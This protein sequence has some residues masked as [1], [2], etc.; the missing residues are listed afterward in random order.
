MKN[1]NSFLCTAL[2]KNVI[3]KI[4]YISKTNYIFLLTNQDYQNNSHLFHIDNIN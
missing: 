3:I 4:Y 2:M 1:I